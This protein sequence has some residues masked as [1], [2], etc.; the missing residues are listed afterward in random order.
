MQGF[1]SQAKV[2]YLMFVIIDI[3]MDLT[4]AFNVVSHYMTKLRFMYWA[5]IKMITRYLKDSLNL[6]L[7]FWQ[8][9]ITLQEYYDI[10]WIGDANNERLRIGYVLFVGVGAIF[11]NCKEEPTIVRS[12][13]K[14][15][16]IEASHKAIKALWL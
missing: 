8:D 7:C 11:W 14:A 15:K 6:K 13:I 3:M 2:G 9:N 16:Y 5:T 10:D 12:T 4:F 1:L